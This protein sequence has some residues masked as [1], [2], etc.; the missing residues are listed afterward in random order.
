MHAPV[1]RGDISGEG[2][3]V[4]GKKLLG[5]AVIQDGIDDGAAV[6]QGQQRLFVGAPAGLG[7]FLGLGVELEFLEDDFA[8]LL[9]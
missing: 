2:L 7:A 9:G 1:A 6:R 4:C 5:G 8:D 3:Y